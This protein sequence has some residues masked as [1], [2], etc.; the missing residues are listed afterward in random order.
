VN[1]IRDDR[2]HRSDEESFLLGP[3]AMDDEAG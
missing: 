3:I 1:R 2:P